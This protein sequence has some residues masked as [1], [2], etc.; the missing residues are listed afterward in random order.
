[1]KK[2]TKTVKSTNEK[3][4][5]LVKKGTFTN[6]IPPITDVSY[7]RLPSGSVYFFE[8]KEDLVVTGI[9]SFS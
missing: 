3:F 8:P 6:S 1:M 7:I 2:A 5:E 4:V 9:R